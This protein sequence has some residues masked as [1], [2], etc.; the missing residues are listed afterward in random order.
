M[1]EARR[2]GQEH[3]HGSA[4]VDR[5]QTGGVDMYEVSREDGSN[6]SL[7]AFAMDA[8]RAACHEAEAENRAY[9]IAWSNGRRDFRF[10]VPPYNEFIDQAV[11]RQSLEAAMRQDSKE[12][13][14][15]KP[16]S[17]DWQSRQ[18]KSPEGER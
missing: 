4:I 1:P 17:D 8:Y 16:M 11:G 12:A 13:R 3:A 18:I 10:R 9:I 6:K 2:R 14:K 7:F 5:S 15:H